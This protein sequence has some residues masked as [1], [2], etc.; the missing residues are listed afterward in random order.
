M[1]YQ[2]QTTN[3][4]YGT[5][6]KLNIEQ[7]KDETER[8]KE[9]LQKTATTLTHQRENVMSRHIFVQGTKKA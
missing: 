2:H 5:Q 7:T 1:N 9:Y 3:K 8:D 6:R 4:L